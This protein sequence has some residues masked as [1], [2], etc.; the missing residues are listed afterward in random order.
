MKWI[1]KNWMRIVSTIAVIAF[2]G[3]IS[4]ID[5]SPDSW[6]AKS[7]RDLTIQDIIYIV[8]IHAVLNRSDRE[9]KSE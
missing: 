8:I 1:K 7:I 2:F 6:F 4:Q 5:T 9:I 3:L